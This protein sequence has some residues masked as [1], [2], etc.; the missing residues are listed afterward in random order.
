M[1]T[2]CLAFLIALASVA[3]A[4][5][6]LTL[7]TAAGHELS[8]GTLADF[9]T[10]DVGGL[11]TLSFTVTNVS[12]AALSN[13]L[14][15]LD[16]RDPSDFVLDASGCTS[17]AVGASGVVRVSFLASVEGKVSQADLHARTASG[18]VAGFDL[19]LTA[20]AGLKRLPV[21]IEEVGGAEFTALSPAYDFGQPMLGQ[22][23]YKTFRL[24]NLGT[25]PLRPVSLQ[26]DEV[27]HH[28]LPWRMYIPEYQGYTEQSGFWLS[29]SSLNAL[30]PGESATFT[31]R[32]S[33]YE[34]ATK[35]KHVVINGDN[36]AVL[37]GVG[38]AGQI[39]N[40]FGTETT[41]TGPVMIPITGGA[42][43]NVVPPFPLAGL[44]YRMGTDSYSAGVVY[45]QGVSPEW[46]ELQPDMLLRWG[47]DTS[48]PT[49]P[50]PNWHQ[51]ST[52]PLQLRANNTV[53][54]PFPMSTPITGTTAATKLNSIA[55]TSFHD[56]VWHSN[57]NLRLPAADKAGMEL[58]LK[59]ARLTG[60]QCVAFVG[61][62]ADA[63]FGLWIVDGVLEGRAGAAR[64]S[65]TAPLTTADWHH[66]AFI[67]S[68]HAASLRVDG[69]EVASASGVS[70]PTLV[71]GFGVGAMVDGT[72]PYDGLVDELRLFEVPA[73]GFDAATQLVANAQP[74]VSLTQ[75]SVE[76]GDVLPGQVSSSTDPLL[77]N[78]GPGWLRILS[79]SLTGDGAADYRYQISSAVIDPPEPFQPPNYNYL[80]GGQTF[81]LFP[82]SGGRGILFLGNPSGGDATIY[83]TGSIT[84]SYA[85][86]LLA[87][88]SHLSVGVSHTASVAGDR[89]ATLRIVTNDPINPV[90]E[91][92]LH[93]RWRRGRSWSC[94]ARAR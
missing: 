3:S 50:F 1:K 85:L 87:P 46:S 12:G 94:S 38:S 86:D 80:S 89:P 35:L 90:H 28:R 54:P 22:T 19:N 2:L 81:V 92:A 69:V 11:K 13:V 32:W 37:G 65:M 59:P 79:V 83:Q 8:D 88:R 33:P 64:V 56:G 49:T 21:R 93:A 9:G 63:G 43:A 47:G 55:A 58:W 34:V 15:T 53:T 68:D 67:V 16:G 10:I 82:F 70:L 23:G 17:L 84:T 62:S 57:T 39:V 36:L 7:R 25:A 45:E 91:I 31:V 51:Q 71:K 29:D 27:S 78:A 14:W 24:T 60:T 26:I 74:S 6:V 4:A 44:H 61:A 20:K 48:A 30:P 72:A 77:K 52:A 75:R 66:V 73:S 40:D 41:P 18:E 42:V 5:Q 76:F